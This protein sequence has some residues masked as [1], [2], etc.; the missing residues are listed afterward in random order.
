M[1]EWRRDAACSVKHCMHLL[2]RLWRTSHL[3]FAKASLSAPSFRVTVDVLSGGM[4]W[5]KWHT[6]STTVALHYCCTWEN[7]ATRIKG[8]L[9]SHNDLHNLWFSSRCEQTSPSSHQNPHG[10]KSKKKR[11]RRRRSDDAGGKRS[12]GMGRCT[13]ISHPSHHPAHSAHTLTLLLLAGVERGI[14]LQSNL[15]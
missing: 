11:R 12:M 9:V 13:D 15:R 4:H 5:L 14:Y 2:L 8:S 6:G 10:K 1:S 7:S 3:C